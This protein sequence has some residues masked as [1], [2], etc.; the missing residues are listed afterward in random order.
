MAEYIERE[1]A[2]KAVAEFIFKYMPTADVAEVEHGKW[3][4]TIEIGYSGAKY[5]RYNCSVCG[6]LAIDKDEE[7][8]CHNCGAKMDGG[9]T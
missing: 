4:I 9:E 3:N 7:K 1:A 8:Y 5:Y 2:I 6:C